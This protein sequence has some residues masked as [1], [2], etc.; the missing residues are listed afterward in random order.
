MG[1]PKIMALIFVTENF[2]EQLSCER[3]MRSVSIHIGLV[4]AERGVDT[5]VHAVSVHFSLLFFLFLVILNLHVIPALLTSLFV[6]LRRVLATLRA[7]LA[8]HFSR[9]PPSVLPSLP[10]VLLLPLS[11]PLRNRPLKY[12]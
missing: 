9:A 5:I 6:L 7:L 3:A 1:G 4:I 2:R 11:P 12:C 10:T 8:S